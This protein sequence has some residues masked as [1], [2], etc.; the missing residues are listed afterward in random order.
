MVAKEGGVHKAAEA[1]NVTPQTISGQ[2]VGMEAYIGFPLFLRQGK[3]MILNEMGRIVYS[4]A[5]DIFNLGIELS[6]VI[7]SQ[8]YRGEVPFHVGV[9]DAIPKVLAFDLLE[10]CFSLDEP[11][12]L[13][14]REG[15]FEFLLS[16]FS[17]NKLDLIISDRPI[18]PGLAIKGYSHFMMESGFSFFVKKDGS[19][20]LK[21]GFPHS[22]HKTPMLF[23]GDKSIQKKLVLSWLDSEGVHPKIMA[24]FDDSA[25]MK[26]F[27]QKGYGVFF[28]PTITEEF[29]LQQFD[30]DVIGRTDLVKE[31]FYAI[32][33]DRKVVHPAT[34]KVIEHA[35]Q[36]QLK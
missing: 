33:P 20:D 27:G 9:I 7:N 5:E 1:L 35:K 15:D 28:A 19:I 14:S 34:E 30:V 23:L 12:I 3:K 32:T 29:V 13:K 22:L 11:V 26:L 21:E 6:D 18:P 17:L 25:L 31:Q 2:L 4:Y 16:E 8:E 36:Y 10:K 24:E